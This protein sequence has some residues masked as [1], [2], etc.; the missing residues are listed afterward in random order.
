MTMHPDELNSRREELRQ[1]WQGSNGW[2]AKYAIEMVPLPYV[3]SG[4]V[5]GGRLIRAGG[6]GRLRRVAERFGHAFRLEL[7]FDCPPYSAKAPG[8]Q[9]VYLIN[10]ERVMMQSPVACGAVGFHPGENELRWIWL[11]PFERGRNQI[12][13]VW[14]RLEL[15][16]GSDFTLDLPV[17]PAMQ[18]FLRRKGVDPA[19]WGGG[20]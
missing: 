2:R 13:D 7:R 9:E 8:G 6:D 11:H 16:Y 5:L 19:R 3:A 14:F 1:Y 12:D 18:S 4:D 20:S 15:L 17:S 10:A